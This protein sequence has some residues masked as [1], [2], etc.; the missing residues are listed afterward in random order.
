M[1]FNSVEFVVFFAVVAVLYFRVEQG[2]RRWLLLGASYVFYMC[3]NPVYI[4]LILASTG[5]DY[6]CGLRLGSA[7]GDASRRRWLVLS[8]ACNLGLL[9]VF[10]YFNF[11]AAWS[12]WATTGSWPEERL[13]DIL[14]PVGISFYTFQ[15]LSYTIDVYQGRREPERRLSAF[16][17]YVSFFP[18]LVAGP[19]ERSTRLLPQ[20]DKPIA[21]SASRAADGLRLMLWGYFKKMVLADNLAL[22]VDP[23]Y[24]DPGAFGGPACA[25]ATVAFAFQIYGDFSGYS[26]IA[27]GAA[28]VLG[29][30]LMENFRRPYFARSIRDFWARWHMSLST[31]FR[32]YL[33]I[34]LGGNRVSRSHWYRNVLIVF[35][36]SGLWH[37][38][39]WTFV[40]WG[41]LHGLY[42]VVAFATADARA[43]WAE[44][45]GLVRLPR[46]RNA[47]Q[48]ACTF[49]L[50][51]FAWVFFRADTLTDAGRLLVRLPSGWGRL[52]SAGGLRAL[53]IL[54]TSVPFLVGFGAVAVLLAVQLVQR[55]RRMRHWLADRPVWVRW[56]AAYALLLAILLL[57]GFDAK[58]F[59]YFQF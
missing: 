53:V 17:L 8:L 20:F 29:I 30:D 55:R 59:I 12:L 39:N 41:F 3:W 47:F 5:V 49:A 15:T 40:V 33:Y 1:L 51:C 57:G 54:D 28:Q 21:F 22:L 11:F 43:R 2:W 45:T 32:D 9:F 44:R 48:V 23:V 6:Y 34:P 56:G 13:L 18:Q 37:G 58:Q 26:D 7:D 46:L 31:W 36:V 52:C 35:V 24:A 16:A 38:A 14:L 25:V 50:V 19:I 27:I 10:K 4:L 42:S